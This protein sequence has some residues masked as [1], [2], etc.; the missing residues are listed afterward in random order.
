MGQFSKRVSGKVG[1]KV[2]NR[3]IQR[4]VEEARADVK[5]DRPMKI[6]GRR[7]ITTREFAA[8]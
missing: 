1:R 3:E 7:N 8:V 6:A 2:G 5:L 4:A